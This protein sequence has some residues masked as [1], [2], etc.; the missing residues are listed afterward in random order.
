MK[1]FFTLCLVLFGTLVSIQANS[2]TTN[3]D[4]SD[5]KLPDYKRQSLDFN[6][7]LYANNNYVKN[8]IENLDGKRNSSYFSNSLYAHYQ[9]SINNRRTQRS[10]Y[11][12]LNFSLKASSLGSEIPSSNS[13]NSFSLSPGFYLNSVNRIYLKNRQ[14]FEVDPYMNYSFS[15]HTYKSDQESFS[16]YTSDLRNNELILKLPLKYG[17]GRIEPVHDARQAIYIL[18]GLKKQNSLTREITSED[19]FK[20]AQLIS[21]IKNKRYLDARLRKIIDLE[22]IDQYLDS[23]NIISESNINYFTTLSDFWDY[24]DR[25]YRNTGTRIAVALLPGYY[26]NDE[27][28]NYNSDSEESRTTATMFHA[29]LEFKYEKPINLKWQNTIDIS[30]Y[31]GYVSAERTNILLNPV[32]K[33]FNI[34]NMQFEFAQKIGFYPNTRT[35]LAFSYSILYYQLFDKTDLSQDIYGDEN[36]G[37]YGLAQLSVNYYISPQ[38][39]VNLSYGLDYRWRSSDESANT[40]SDFSYNL[41]LANNNYLNLINGDQDIKEIS[42]VLRIS[43]LYSLF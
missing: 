23:N 39:K 36:R 15:K 3:F 21:K 37:L 1:H 26:F 16:D 29:G 33:K 43:F 22:T 20:F 27:K 6:F 7:N 14:F 19:V 18:E 12:S 40:I 28:S 38:F 31:Y 13:S 9:S 5:Y 11:A 4:L 24:G 8:T 32:E 42:Q 25:I 41:I 17:F 10:L 2:Q 30:S 34:P 35:D